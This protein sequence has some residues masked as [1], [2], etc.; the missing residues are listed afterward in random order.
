MK[1][2]RFL[3]TLCMLI[4]L[5]SSC[6]PSETY[7]TFHQDNA[8][9]VRVKFD[10][11]TKQE[12]IKSQEPD[13]VKKEGY[14]ASW[15]DYTIE[16]KNSSFTVNAEYS[17]IT[18]Y[19]FF[20]AQGVI[21]DQVPFTIENITGTNPKLPDDKV[22]TCPT[23]SW[24]E[25]YWEDYTLSLQNIIVNAR[26]DRLKE[27]NVSFEANGEKIGED[28][29]ITKN[30]LDGDG[31]I[32]SSLIPNEVKNFKVD[33]CDVV[34]DF[35]I[36][37]GKDTIIR[38]TITFHSFYIRFVDFDGKQVG[39]LVPY[40]IESTWE[41][42]SKP[43][44]P[45]ISGYT[46]FWKQ[47][48]LSY[49]D[50][51]IV[52]SKP[53]K[54]AN[55]YVLTYDNG[56]TQTVTF[57]SEY[58]LSKPTSAKE[59]WFDEEGHAIPNKGIYTIPGNISLHKQVV[60]EENFDSD[61]VP[62]FIDLANSLNIK[63]VSIAKG[64]GFNGSNALK[65]EVSEGDFGLRVKKEYLAEV[66][67]GETASLNF[68]IRSSIYNNNFRHRT[69]RSNICYEVNS[70]FNLNGLN[71]DYKE[72]SFTKEMYLNHNEDNGDYMIYGGNPDGGSCADSVI[73]IDS[74]IF[75][76]SDI[77]KTQLN[78]N[79]FENSGVEV[80]RTNGGAYYR[81]AYKN[82]TE[83]KNDF[84]IIQFTN[85]LETPQT[86]SF[87]NDNVTEGRKSLK[88]TKPNGYVALFLP[89]NFTNELKAS[90]SQ[91]FSFDMYSTM[92]I[93]S[94]PTV[95]NLIDGRNHYL[96]PPS[97]LQHPANT[98]VTYTFTTDQITD[99][100]NARF[101]II[102]GSTAGSFYFDNFKIVSE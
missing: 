28:I 24:A 51:Q 3:L 100:P 91:K 97:G 90:A 19:V 1:K 76:E 44:T 38:P 37:E 54:T 10:S 39:D 35:R 69:N 66:F 99:D 101:L 34:W 46:T 94:T 13:L 68:Y 84:F 55:E 80:D 33:W 23:Y 77:L 22:P 74:F 95:G 6:S 41:S 81:F 21:V 20:K 86:F 16:G 25:A 7:V 26:Y 58:T 88:F 70:K 93:N 82:D 78:F 96:N 49:R 5:A 48:E 60:N 4:P 92:L 9:D 73:Y 53:E 17:A 42:I 62:D 102:Q 75:N 71:V 57:D 11:N 40:T 45:K 61:L 89:Q 27:F 85:N 56:D 15:E 52:E 64:E 29:R 50:D 65:I 18:Y 72:F 32:R 79:G 47:T 8:D 43:E 36:K 30:D 83:I 2:I 98:W 67:T 63:S 59:K 87:S 12:D 31:Q 14:I